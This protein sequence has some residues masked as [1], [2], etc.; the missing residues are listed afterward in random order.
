MQ[1]QKAFV[2]GMARSGAAAARL[3]LARGCEVT[4]CDVRT[5]ANGSR[6]A[7]RPRCAQ[8]H[9]HLGEQTPLPLIAGMTA[10]IVSPGI[11]DTHPA[12]LRARELGV[13]VMGELE[14][15][16]RESRASSWP[17]PAPTARPPPRP[18]WARSSKTPVVARGWWATSARPTRR[19]S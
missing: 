3:L 15:A 12:V 10:L 13:E 6:A 1:I 19:Q 18:C 5:R 11:P 2:L 14:Y 4:I 9:W 7:G 17:S 16:Y 8:H